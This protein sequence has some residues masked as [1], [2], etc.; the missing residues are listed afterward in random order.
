MPKE[1]IIQIRN[2]GDVNKKRIN[3]EDVEL[4]IDAL[5]ENNQEQYKVVLHLDISF[6]PYFVYAIMDYYNE[7]KKDIASEIKEMKN[8]ITEDQ[9]NDRN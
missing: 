7:V 8:S 5:G 3:N 2:I 1:K 9:Q 4:I 6:L